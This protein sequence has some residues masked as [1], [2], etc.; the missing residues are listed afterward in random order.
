MIVSICISSTHAYDW[1]RQYRRPMAD[2]PPR[3][4]LAAMITPLG[5]ALIA[6]EQPVLRAN[7]LTMWGYIVLNALDGRPARTQAALAQA[8]GADKPRITPV[9]DELHRQGLIDRA[10]APADRRARLISITARGRRRRAA[11]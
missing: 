9:R 2:S 1:S 3:R 10:P 11:T 6:A 4:D 8:I 7:D 5:R